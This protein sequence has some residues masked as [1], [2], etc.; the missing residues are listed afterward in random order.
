MGYTMH[1]QY[2]PLSDYPY[3]DVYYP[4]NESYGNY[5]EERTKKASSNPIDITTTSTVLITPIWKEVVPELVLCPEY[6]DVVNNECIQM[7]LL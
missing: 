4:L 2:D 7:P 6:Y 1:K 5:T 3:I